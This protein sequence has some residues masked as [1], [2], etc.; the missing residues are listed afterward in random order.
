MFTP[1]DRC[2][3]GGF[4]AGG[5]NPGAPPSIEVAL[6]TYQSAR[7]LR[8]QLDSLFAQTEQN[9]TLL[10]ADDGSQD[11]TVEILH[12]YSMR[13]EGRI[14]IVA[15]EKQPGGAPGNF[16]RLI[17]H[18][19]ADYLFLCDHDDVWSPNKMELS[20]ARMST[21]V[22]RHGDEV[23]LLVHTD[24][25]VVDENLETLGPSMF[26]YQ[27]IDPA[28][29]DVASLLLTNVASGC[30]MVVNRALYQKAR[31]IP[32]EAVMHDHWL[33]LVAAALGA[34]ACVDESTILYRQHGGNVV[35]AKGSGT[36]SLA[37]LIQRARV[38]LLSDDRQ[39]IIRRH[40]RQAAI[41]EQRYGS[42]MSHDA[43][44]TAVAL[45]EIWSIS[46]WRRFARLRRHG[47]GPPGLV[48]NVALLIV[49]SRGMRGEGDTQQVSRR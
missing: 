47:L 34:I 33:T 27:N 30:T 38:N 37:S 41:L 42:E 21:L 46:W 40:S 2:E 14:R 6:A 32:P 22:E 45:A 5:C 17:E 39:R 28:R 29:N 4:S 35:G 18:A 24:L 15:R 25:T 23:P 20:L 48:R 13:Y 9:F 16:G 19:S 43:R 36:A 49:V 26:R 3:E 1:T 7:F 44:R 31:P 12:E 8:Q 11:A 10:V